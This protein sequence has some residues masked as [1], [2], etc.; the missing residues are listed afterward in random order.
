MSHYSAYIQNH[1]GWEF[2]GVLFADEGITGTKAGSPQ[3]QRMLAGCRAGEIH[4]IITKAISCF[5]RNTVTLLE[6]VQELKAL[7]VG[8]NFEEQNTTPFAAIEN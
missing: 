7:G 8:V 3:F 4:M 1:P 5:A 2:A 6:T